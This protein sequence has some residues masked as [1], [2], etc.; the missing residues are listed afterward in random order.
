MPNG[1][2]Q[3]QLFEEALSQAGI[4]PSEVDYLEVDGTG[5]ELG[6]PIEVRAAAAVY[7]RGCHAERPLLLGTVKRNIGH[8]EWAA[9]VAGL[10]KVLLAMRHGLIPRH[11]HL[12]DPSPQTE[13]DKLSV[14]VTT[15]ATA[16]PTAPDRPSTAG[17]SAFGISGTNAHLV[18]EGYGAMEGSDLAGAD[19]G[20]LLA[21]PG[22]PRPVSVRLP[23]PH[24]DLQRVQSGLGPHRTRLLPLSGKS[25]SALRELAGQYLSWFDEH[26]QQIDSEACLGDVPLFPPRLPIVA[27][28]TGWVMDVSLG[29]GGAAGHGNRG[30]GAFLHAVA[31][32]YEAG[33][34]LD[35][36][37]LFAGEARRRISLPAYPF[38]RR[39]FWFEAPESPS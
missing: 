38:Q 15:E 31:G 1:T 25:E 14:R 35:L 6:D 11:L 20:R 34:A 3:E 16:W 29:Q 4:V 37:G 22:P 30:A 7:G 13:W 32:A 9:G 18:V 23:A 17:I 21:G 2:A 28:A 39:S 12:K 24:E 8:L 19:G 10:I 27:G 33:L 36:A 26:T 5:S